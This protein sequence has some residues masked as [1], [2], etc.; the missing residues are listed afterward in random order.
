MRTCVRV[1]A[2]VCARSPVCVYVCVCMCACVCMRA[3]VRARECVCLGGGGLRNAFSFPDSLQ[4]ITGLDLI[5]FK[6]LA[7][8]ERRR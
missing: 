1:R 4:D 5:Y 6:Y 7:Y 2:C 3:C 8:E